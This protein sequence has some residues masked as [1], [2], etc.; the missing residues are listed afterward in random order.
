M[1]CLRASVIGLRRHAGLHIDLLTQNPEVT[2]DKVL[3]HRQPPDGYAHLPITANIADLM[4]SDVI[5]LSTPTSSH[6]DY[7]QDLTTYGGYILLEKPAVN[8]GEQIRALLD[9]PEDFKRRLKVNYNFNFHEFRYLLG[10]VKQS[11]ELGKIF[12][13]DV[14]TSHGVAF[15]HDWDNA[16]RVE[17]ETGLGPLETTGIHYIQLALQEFGMCKH[18][19]VSTTCLSGRP[20]SV[21]TGT[22][23]MEMA[24][25]TLVRIRHSYAAPYGVRFEI[26]GTDGY[27]VYDGETAN[28][29]HPRDTLDDDGRFT[30]PPIHQNWKVPF[31]KAWMQSLA[32]SQG[33]FLK[34]AAEGTSFDP[35]DFD[36]DVSAMTVLLNSK[37]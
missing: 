16:W 11:G 27:L 14:H 13:L 5:V 1:A 17:N 32:R 23:N 15:R 25:G 30:S 28:L 36:R 12:A 18:S 20:G 31:E 22:L 10:R 29:Y 4:D 3:Y 35:R 9:L 26:W 24:D 21:D 7:I 33:H 2:L 34:T 37:K 19:A 8:T 6:F